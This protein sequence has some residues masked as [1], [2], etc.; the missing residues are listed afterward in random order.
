MEDNADA[1]QA[2]AELCR[3]QGYACAVALD[4]PQGLAAAIDQ[5]PEIVIIDIGLPGL[6]GFAVATE[7]RRLYGSNM[8]LIAMSGYSALDTRLRAEQAGFDA[9]L[10]K[11]VDIPALLK[12]LQRQPPA[13]QTLP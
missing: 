1:L 9:F 6:D 4:G 2:M 11:P 13:I 8:T 7:L 12:Q 5:Q 3:V 10:V